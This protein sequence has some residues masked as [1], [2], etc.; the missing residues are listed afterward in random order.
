MHGVEA[1]VRLRMQNAGT[2]NPCINEP[3][4]AHPG[5]PPTLPATPNH[6]R[7]QRQMT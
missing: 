5:Q 4:E 1:H 7:Y 3:Q 2:G 6:A